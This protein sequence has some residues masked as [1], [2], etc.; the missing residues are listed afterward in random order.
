MRYSE[1]EYLPFFYP[2]RPFDCYSPAR[3]GEDNFLNRLGI[4]RLLCRA[5][6]DGLQKVTAHLMKNDPS[7]YGK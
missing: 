3:C 5:L 7:F 4:R 1:P 6:T 2:N